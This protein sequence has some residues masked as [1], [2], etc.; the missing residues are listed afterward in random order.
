M[1][2]GNVVIPG[3]VLLVR[4]FGYH[5]EHL[6]VYVRAAGYGNLGYVYCVERLYARRGRMANVHGYCHIGLGVP[7]AGTRAA[8]AAFFLH[9]GAEYDLAVQLGFF[10]YIHGL[11]HN[12]YAGAVIESFAGNYVVLQLHRR[13]Q[14]E[15]YI[16]AHAHKLTHLICIKSRIAHHIVYRIGLCI[17]AR[18][19]KVRRNCAHNG[20]EHPFAVHQYLAAGQHPRVNARN[21]AYAE[22]AVLLNIGHHHADFVHMRLHQQHGAVVA[23]MRIGVAHWIDEYIVRI[24]FVISLDN[25]GHGNLVAGYARGGGQSG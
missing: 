16:V 23:Y 2:G 6:G 22:Q 17:V 9:G 1:R 12:G 10:K 19:L 21:G 7:Y 13:Q 4:G 14:R 24:G 18:L 8:A 11:E 5:F 25:L 3:D 20:I 15:R